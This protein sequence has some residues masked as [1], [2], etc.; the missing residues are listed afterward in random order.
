MV[1]INFNAP[2]KD[3]KESTD[4]FVVKLKERGYN[5]DFHRIEG[6]GHGSLNSSESINN[7]LWKLKLI[8]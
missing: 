8:N 1:Y 5:I 2:L 6:G 4:K 7:W 3:E